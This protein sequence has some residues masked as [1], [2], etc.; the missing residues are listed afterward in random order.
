VVWK[1]DAQTCR[2]VA[3]IDLFVDGGLVGT[4]LIAAGGTSNAY[5]VSAGSH[6]IGAS[7]A[8]GAGLVWPSVTHNISAGGTF[9]AVLT[10]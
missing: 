6:V 8:D 5:P 9:N 1:I 3:P 7:V 4:E 2:G 10:C